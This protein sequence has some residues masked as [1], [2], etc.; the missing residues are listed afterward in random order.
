MQFQRVLDNMKRMGH[1]TVTDANTQNTTSITESKSQEET[2]DYGP[3]II[4]IKN[5]E[6]IIETNDG[7]G[8]VKT[9]DLE[10]LSI[11]KAPPQFRSRKC[12]DEDDLNLA[13]GILS[14]RSFK[15]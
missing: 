6:A 3:I 12:S 5:G 15:V 4:K 1:T 8:T 2:K 13:R 14:G 7:F 9:A 10:S 11:P